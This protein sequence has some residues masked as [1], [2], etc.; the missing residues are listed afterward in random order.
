[1]SMSVKK[2]WGVL[3]RT[4]TISEN[5][6]KDNLKRILNLFDLTAIGV[7]A[8]LGCGVY[9]LAGAVAKSIA[10]PAVVLSF[11]V[12]A[13]VSAFSG[14]CYAEFAGR[15]PQAG[16][17]YIY[18]YVTVGEFPAFII[19]WNLIIEYI[20]G[21]AAVAKAMCNYVDSLLG[22]P[23]EQIMTEYFPIH[24][25][26]LANYPDIAS[27]IAVILVTSL[28]AWGVQESTILN[29]IFTTINILTVILVIVSG[30]FQVNFSYWSIPKNSIPET[31]N[32]GNGGFLP[33][34]WTGVAAGSAKCFYAFIGFDS[35]ATTGEETK[36]PKKT[37]P[38]AIMTSLFIVSVAYCG[39]ATVLTLMLPYYSQDSKAPLPHLY[40]LLNMQLIKYLV[41]GGALFALSASLLSAMFPLPRIL[42]AMSKDGLLF[43]FL[44]KV[45]PTTK[46]PIIAT[47]ISGV[48]SGTLATIFNLD[49]LIDMAS[50]GTLQAYTIVC[51]SIL[52]LHY[53]DDTLSNENYIFRT[54]KN[55]TSKLFHLS[56]LKTTNSDTQYVSRILIAI[57]CFSS[58]VFGFS[59][60]KFENSSNENITYGLC[61]ISA[62][63]LVITLMMLSALPKVKEDLSFKTPL[64]P[65][66]PC[67]S[68]VWNTY[69]MMIL[70]YKTWVRFI[71]WLIF[72]LITYFCYSIN[73]STE[74]NKE[75]LKDNREVK[76]K[77][78]I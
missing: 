23:Q 46:T 37:I 70:D 18:S 62:L 66:I 39:V 34:G 5:N 59:L 16:S 26:F 44:S 67:L 63:I 27:F 32:G 10:G 60:S 69:F 55:I 51:I 22:Y 11:M 47:I 33:F 40:D 48:F 49:Q 36:N 31:I 15:V 12:A 20:I 64:V 75:L 57:F 1:M 41:S 71:F 43:N 77:T 6:D 19:G 72:G 24:V 35:I 52:I 8:T 38:L 21:T 25:S 17:A 9:V 50:I 13:V 30:F 61:T 2:S 68:I 65:L 45:N 56:Y 53:N 42:Y 14:L 28:L 73:H 29:S 78:T 3:T 74:N 54:K 7:G 4:K 58:L 76:N